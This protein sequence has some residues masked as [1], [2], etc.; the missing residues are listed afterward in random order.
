MAKSPAD[1]AAKWAKNY[2]ASAAEFEKAIND[3]TADQNPMQRAI[4]AGDAYIK[5]VTAAY[6]DKRWEKGLRKVNFE[7]WKAKTIKLG[8][9]RM[10]DGANAAKPKVEKFMDFWMPKMNDIKAKVRAMKA[11]GDTTGL[12]R[13]TAVYN[14]NKA[15]KYKNQ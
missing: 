11:K 1:V 5:N 14:F 3:L 6:N 10:V 4:N 8:K 7:D 12:E 15:N 9:A 2:A 13:F